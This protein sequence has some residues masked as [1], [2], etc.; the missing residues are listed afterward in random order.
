M[1]QKQLSNIFDTRRLV[2]ILSAFPEVGRARRKIGSVREQ[3]PSV[4]DEE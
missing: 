4:F 2:N 3:R 1:G